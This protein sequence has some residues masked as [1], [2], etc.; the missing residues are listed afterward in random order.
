MERGSTV[1]LDFEGYL[2]EF[3]SVRGP[4]PGGLYTISIDGQYIG[5]VNGSRMWDYE[6]PFIIFQRHDLSPTERHNIT[7]TA[8]DVSPYAPCRVQSFVHA[9]VAPTR[10]IYA[11]ASPTGIP[12]PNSGS[13]SPSGAPIGAII[14]GVVGG[15]AVLGLIGLFTWYLHHRRVQ[16]ERIDDIIFPD[17]SNT[18]S[19]AVRHGPQAGP[20]VPPVQFDH[21]ANHMAEHPSYPGPQWGSA[22][23]AAAAQPLHHRPATSASTSSQFYYP[24]DPFPEKAS[25]QAWTHTPATFTPLGSGGSSSRPLSVVSSPRS[26]GGGSSTHGHWLP[27]GAATP[28]PPGSTMQQQHQPLDAPPQYD[29]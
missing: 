16:E 9:A 19:S 2:I 29:G 28:A 26:H 18:G 6:S 20:Q 5:I 15:I 24:P 3:W 21:S 27:P 17:L 4:S 12:V 22:V 10:P 11:V 7:V 1:T 14:G 25:I 23:G 13:S 8:V